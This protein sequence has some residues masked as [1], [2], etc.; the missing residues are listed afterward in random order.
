MSAEEK[1][2]HD[3]FVDAMGDDALWKKLTG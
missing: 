3:A 2:A 1:A